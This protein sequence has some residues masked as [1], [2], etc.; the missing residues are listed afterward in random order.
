MINV[1]GMTRKNIYLILYPL[2]CFKNSSNTCD[3]KRLF[4]IEINGQPQD[5]KKRNHTRISD[6]VKSFNM[7]SI[8]IQMSLR[9]KGK[10]SCC[11]KVC[12][13]FPHIPMHILAL[14]EF[15]IHPICV[16]I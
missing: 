6:D 5:K 4:L 9:E 15:R 2:K 1:I 14:M 13:T 3:A 11:G 16:N 10:K 8:C 12:F 7:N